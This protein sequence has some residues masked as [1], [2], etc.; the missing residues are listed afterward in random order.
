MASLCQI[1]LTEPPFK[2][3]VFIGEYSL[4]FPGNETPFKIVFLQVN[5][6]CYSP[7]T[8]TLLSAGEDTNLVLWDIAAKRLEVS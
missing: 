1:A 8:E 3:N 4:L 7:E 2:I 6:V 5:I